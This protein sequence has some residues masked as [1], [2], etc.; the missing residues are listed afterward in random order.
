MEIPKGKLI[1]I[2]G[3]EDKGTEPEPNFQ[4]KN[5]LN[6]FELQILS[7]IVHEAGGHDAGIEV[8]TSASSIPAEVGS[9]YLE[10][11]GKLGCRNISVMDIRNRNDAQKADMIARISKCDA[12]MFSGGNQL[13]L[14]S[15][16]GGTEF[17][18]ILC[19]RYHNETNFVI[20]GTS[21]GAMAMSNTMIYQGNSGEALLKG[22]VKITTGLAF[23]KDLIIDSHFVTRGR[24]GRLTQAV[25]ANPSCIGIGLGEDT[26]VLISEGNYME[27]IGSGLVI[28]IDGH[29]IL[30][31]NIADLKEGSPISIENII[32]HVLAKGNCYDLKR[33]KFSAEVL[34][35]K[36]S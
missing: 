2:G 21:A 28:V 35:E 29:G 19:S 5:N 24:F 14:S 11:F 32:V 36:N 6:F 23:I 27:A 15:I 30:H 13:R 1:A 34:Q 9:N 3:N 33:R 26:G 31:S 16:F 10:A 12:V 22:E 25:A 20:A 4:Q 17:L 7:R 18:N 8:I